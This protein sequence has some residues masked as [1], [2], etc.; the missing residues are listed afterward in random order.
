MEI[1][2]VVVR[3]ALSNSPTG[4]YAPGNVSCPST[5]LI[6]NANDISDNEKAF[7]AKRHAVTN[8]A[9]TD[10]LN[11]AAMVD[12][13]VRAF[14]QSYSPTIG[15]AFSGGGYRALLNGGGEFA[16]FDSRTP[17]SLAAGHVG[18]LLQSAT[19]VAGLS[20]GSWL[21][22]SVVINNFT[23]VQALQRSGDVW[24]FTNNILAPEG[25]LHIVDTTRYYND[26]HDEVTAKEQAGFDVSLT[27]YWS[28]AL[29]RQFVNFTN[30]GPGITYSSIAKTNDFVNGDMPFP[31]IV[32]DGRNPGE[33]LIS[34]NATVF[35]FN[36]FEFGSFDPTLFAFT[37][38]EFL[39]TN[40]T[41]GIPNQKNICVRGFDNVG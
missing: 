1:D 4:G 27:D 2:D 39:G 11:R 19:Y 20:G 34:S 21:L 14:M 17:G 35:E 5:P 6:R 31:I 13:D 15:I 3:R 29:S 8:K 33:L 9:L 30:G 22:G 24:D 7:V 12:F 41:G 36:P 25:E 28:R 26:L 10:F 23:T 18:G 38:M 40:M 32:A 37:P 16:A